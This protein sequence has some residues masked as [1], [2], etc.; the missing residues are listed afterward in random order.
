[1]TAEI[2]VGDIG[3]IFRYTFYDDGDI[4]N[5]AAATTLKGRF[6]RPDLSTFDVD[7]T[8]EGD[9]SDGIAIYTIIANDIN[10]AGSWKTQ[11]FAVLP[12]GSWNT[13]T[14]R[15]PVGDNIEIV[16]P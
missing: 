11:G 16:E 7:L 6:R 3:T 2:H 14:H 15:F 5:I 1:M 12:L 13:D 4:L 9:G 8:L 10:Q